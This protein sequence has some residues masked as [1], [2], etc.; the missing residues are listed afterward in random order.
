LGTSIAI[1]ST[2][3]PIMTSAVPRNEAEDQIRAP[4]IRIAAGRKI[5]APC[6]RL[7]VIC[8]SHFALE[9]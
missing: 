6:A 5:A 9:D 2:M 7:P 4:A 1:V 8:W 3:A